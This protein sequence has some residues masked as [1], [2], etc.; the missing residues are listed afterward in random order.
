MLT[1]HALYRLL[2][3][4]SREY[5]APWPFGTTE[6]ESSPTPNRILFIARDIAMNVDAAGGH[7]I[8]ARG[9]WTKVDRARKFLWWM[10]NRKYPEHDPGL[11]MSCKADRCIAPDHTVLAD[12]PSAYKPPPPKA[13]RPVLKLV[14]PLPEAPAITREGCI[15]A[16]LRY[17]TEQ[18]ARQTANKVTGRRQYAYKCDLPGCGGWH[19]T[20]IKPG[21]YV[22]KKVGVW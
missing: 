20:K 5:Y 21:K 12:S 3:W 1:L 13:K 11:A 18:L 19:L 16:K 2:T 7:R 17:P 15:S 22:R 4:R 14:P 8:L 6:G 9:C 10:E